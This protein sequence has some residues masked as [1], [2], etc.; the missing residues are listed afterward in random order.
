MIILED[1]IG[2][3]NNEEK[4]ESLLLYFIAHIYPVIFPDDMQTF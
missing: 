1:T 3:M 4:Q 2:G